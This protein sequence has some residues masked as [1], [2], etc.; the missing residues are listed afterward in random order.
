M[1][2]GVEYAV[3]KTLQ[4][5]I[6]RLASAK[7]RKGDLS[8]P[9]ADPGI[10]L[11]ATKAKMGE[12]FCLPTHGDRVAFHGIVRMLERE[13]GLRLDWDPRAGDNGQ[14]ERIHLLKV[15]IIADYLGEPLS[16]VEARDAIEQLNAE[17]VPVTYQDKIVSISERW[18]HGSAAARVTSAD[19]KRF[20]DAFRVLHAVDR[21]GGADVLLRRLSTQLFRDSKRIESLVGPLSYLLDWADDT[22]GADEEE[23]RDMF[24]EIGLVKFPQPMLLASAVAMSVLTT[25]QAVPLVHP[26]VGLQPDAIG[27]IQINAG[28]AVR[29]VLTIENLATFNEMALAAPNDTLVIYTA[30]NPTPSWA[31]A[32]RRIVLA[33]PDARLLHWGDIDRGGFRIASRVASAAPAGR[34]LALMHMTSGVHTGEFAVPAATT[35]VDEVVVRCRRNGWDNEA[36]AMERAALF[37]EQEVIAITPEVLSLIGW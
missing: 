26:Y 17:S 33:I 34:S 4:R 16:W 36:L 23:V 31:S 15:D 30:G 22:V 10:S 5:L 2:A 19:A 20:V 25:K 32:Y 6:G 8:D 27:G 28:C 7:F 13:G 29:H 9:P 21:A 1:T 18:R 14:I 11:P 3:A 37:Q 12:Y 24:A 35:H